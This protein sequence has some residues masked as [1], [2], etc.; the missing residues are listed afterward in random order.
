[1]SHGGICHLALRNGFIRLC[2]KP[3]PLLP[4][5]LICSP[6]CVIPGKRVDEHPL[7]GST[8]VLGTRLRPAYCSNFGGAA[9][10]EW[11][12]APGESDGPPAVS[13]VT[14]A[15]QH[16]PLPGGHPQ[17]AGR[18]VLEG[19]QGLQSRRC[20]QWLQDLH[21]KPPIQAGQWSPPQ[22]AL[23]GSAE[24][25]QARLSTV[26]PSEAGVHVKVHAVVQAQLLDGRAAKEAALHALDVHSLRGVQQP[27]MPPSAVK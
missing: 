20:S 22:R 2:S 26:L 5:A 3:D 15:A 8:T 11:S 4:V 13:T 27:V 1:M 25:Q 17:A 21:P 10:A 18:R 9:A 6:P 24:L 12:S 16:Y 23:R 19:Q 14:H 7:R